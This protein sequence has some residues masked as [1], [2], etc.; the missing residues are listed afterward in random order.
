MFSYEEINEEWC[1]YFVQK[2]IELNFSWSNIRIN[3]NITYKYVTS[4]PNKY[5]SYYM[6]SYNQNITQEIVDANLDKPWNNYGLN[7]NL[8]I[9]WKLRQKNKT[10]F[11]I[12]IFSEDP[13]INWRLIQEN[14]H[15]N[16]NWEQISKCSSIT[17]EI[18]K[19]NMDKPWVWYSMSENLNITLEIIQSNPQIPFNIYINPNI[20][21]EY[22]KSVKNMTWYNEFLLG[23]NKFELEKN[24]FFRKKLQEWFKK[25]SLKEE[26]IAKLWHPK[27]FEKFKYYDPETFENDL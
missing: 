25:S 20:T 19:E 9:A 22:I 8:N 15:E 2:M 6:L 7:K 13:N 14:P 17:W 10:K 21:F 27:N 4:N 3:S 16:L 23:T 18:I 1:E 26:L 11:D 24:I 12:C 5:W